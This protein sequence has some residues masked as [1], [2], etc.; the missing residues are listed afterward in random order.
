M[1][2]SIKDLMEIVAERLTGQRVVVHCV[3]DRFAVVEGKRIVATTHK[4]LDG[5]PV[6]TMYERAY[7]D[8]GQSGLS[9]FL[10]ECAHVLMHGD[11]LQPRKNYDP[12]ATPDTDADNPMLRA[13]RDRREEEADF[14]A[15]LWLRYAVE[16]TK[17]Y[18]QND[19]G[20]LLYSLYSAPEG[21]WLQSLKN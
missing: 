9:H 8:D 1:G 20:L 12:V 16:H 7:I 19:V 15:D 18:E 17:S 4:D 11:T 21:T 2:H 5:V 13:I 14:L 3:P 6:I 10:H